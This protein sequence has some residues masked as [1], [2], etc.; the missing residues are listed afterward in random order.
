MIVTLHPTTSVTI[1]P[2]EVDKPI[3]VHSEG[4]SVEIKLSVAEAERLVF[5]LENALRFYRPTG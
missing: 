5:A 3:R 4:G 1:F 2:E